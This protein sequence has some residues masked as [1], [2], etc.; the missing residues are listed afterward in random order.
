M[1]V[2]ASMRPINSGLANTRAFSGGLILLEVLVA[3]AILSLALGVL[4]QTTGNSIARQRVVDNKLLAASHAV[5]VLAELEYGDI[6]AS[7][8]SG[9][10]DDVY[11][12]S[13][14]LE[15]V[16]TA[17]ALVTDSEHPVALMRVN[18]QIEWLESGR[19]KSYQLHT[20]RMVTK[21]AR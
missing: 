12:W 6:G 19:E 20:K 10:I 8:I 1:W 13:A 15:P 4:L 17:H 3:F 7:A 11:R 2:L 21:K 14:S 9:R 18:V 5:N 16:A